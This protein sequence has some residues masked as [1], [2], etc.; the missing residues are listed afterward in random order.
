M[1]NYLFIFFYSFLTRKCRRKNILLLRNIFS[2]LW[3]KYLGTTG[4]DILYHLLKKFEQSIKSPEMTSF[5]SYFEN[6]HLKSY[7][8]KNRKYKQYLQTSTVLDY[9]DRFFI[10]FRGLNA[11]LLQM[12]DMKYK[13]FKM[14]SIYNFKHCRNIRSFFLD[15][16]SKKII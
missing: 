3:P 1:K 13:K 16:I 14:F 8:P 11:L 2:E 4:R 12:F 5:L 7:S 15:E 9:D 10:E 6:T